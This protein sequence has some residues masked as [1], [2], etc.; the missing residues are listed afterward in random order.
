MTDT[1]LSNPMEKKV[2]GHST[3]VVG[4]NGTI[5]LG[6]NEQDQEIDDPDT[7]I[8]N[9]AGN[10]FL[11][12]KY[13]STEKLEKLLKKFMN[14]ADQTECDGSMISHVYDLLGREDYSDNTYPFNQGCIG[15]LAALADPKISKLVEG[16]IGDYYYGYLI[17]LIKNMVYFTSQMLEPR[18]T[19]ELVLHQIE[20]YHD[21]ITESQVQYLIE[22]YTR[23][24]KSLRSPK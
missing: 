13:R 16:S 6:S 22:Y 15:L 11:K 10:S 14:T 1:N 8:T 5:N 9:E 4:N 24:F 23:H 20:E 21:D 7:Y 12:A 18:F 2:N 19:A 3:I 17:S